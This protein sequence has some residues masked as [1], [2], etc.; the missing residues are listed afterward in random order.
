MNAKLQATTFTKRKFDQDL[1]I[2]KVIAMC[3]NNDFTCS[4]DLNIALEKIVKDC[5][6]S[7]AINSNYRIKKS[8]V[9]RDLIVVVRDIQFG[10]QTIFI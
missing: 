7:I 5:T 9:N 8:H 3:E 4:N 6:R 10:I 1:A 2:S